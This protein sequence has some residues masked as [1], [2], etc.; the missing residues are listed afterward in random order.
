MQKIFFC[1]PKPS[2]HTTLRSLFIIMQRGLEI[3]KLPFLASSSSYHVLTLFHLCE[4]KRQRER[5][6]EEKVPQTFYRPSS[7]SS[8]KEKG[9]KRGRKKWDQQITSW[10]IQNG[11]KSFGSLSDTGI[12]ACAAVKMICGTVR[13]YAIN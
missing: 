12:V 10:N 13:F 9:R 2:R 3:L 11:W 5:E 4:S 8:L 7:F 1:F 6:R